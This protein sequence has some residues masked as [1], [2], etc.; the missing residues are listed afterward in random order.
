VAFSRDRVVPKI[1]N[2]MMNTKETRRRCLTVDHVDTYDAKG[3]PKYLGWMY[4]GAARA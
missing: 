4:Q 2:T 3:D 1:M